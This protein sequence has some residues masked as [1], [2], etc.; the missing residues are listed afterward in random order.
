MAGFSD[1]TKSHRRNM[2]T[3]S[4]LGLFSTVLGIDLSQLEIYGIT[5]GEHAKSLQSSGVELIPGLLGIALI[6]S[7]LMFLFSYISDV[8][9][10]L[11]EAYKEEEE[12]LSGENEITALATQLFLEDK[13]DIDAYIERARNVGAGKY[14]AGDE[15]IV[16]LL[17]KSK[18]EWSS[19]A[20]WMKK[21]GEL[22]H[23][24]IMTLGIMGIV[25]RH[26]IPLFITILAI[27]H[28]AVPAWSVFLMFF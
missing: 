3:F 4:I 20:H 25:L 12:A 13:K 19:S 2:V 14:K 26:G 7:V 11:A 27:F 6:Y 22:P 9:A 10:N 17:K 5:V 24:I 8:Y 15:E 16:E 18:R 23:S 28:L 1:E 21:I